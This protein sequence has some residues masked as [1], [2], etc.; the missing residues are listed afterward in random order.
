MEG[1][2][3]LA[4][5]KYAGK[6]LRRLSNS[7]EFHDVLHGF[8]PA[9]GTRTA[10]IK[11]KLFQ[12]LAALERVPAYEIFLDLHKAYDAVDRGRLLDLLEA[13][14]VGP[15]TQTLLQQNFWEAQR[16]VARQGEYYCRPFR[17]GRGLTQGDPNV[18][19]PVQ[20]RV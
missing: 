18:P 20:C 9:C 7:I 6:T 1:F 17:A 16:F 8:R 5:W 19:Y 12:Q 4:F 11:A 14:G 10:I 13:Y 15:P 2:V 3:A